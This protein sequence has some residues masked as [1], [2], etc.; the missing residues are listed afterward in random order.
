[1]KK[2]FLQVNIK[3]SD[4]NLSYLK[5]TIWMIVERARLQNLS[6]LEVKKVVEVYFSEL[7]FSEELNEDASAR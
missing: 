2:R 3:L 5:S 4:Q 7:T 6:E 1:M